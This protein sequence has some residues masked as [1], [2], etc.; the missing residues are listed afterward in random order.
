MTS[1]LSEVEIGDRRVRAGLRVVLLI[2]VIAALTPPIDDNFRFLAFA[3]AGF[4][5]LT[6]PLRRAPWRYLA[7]FA[8]VFLAIWLAALMPRVAIEEGHNVFVYPNEPTALERDLPPPVFAFMR[9]QFLEQYPER[10]CRR[11]Y[12]WMN[13]SLPD[14]VFAF[15]SDSIFEP[16]RYS[17]VVDGID[18]SS[19]GELRAT[20]ANDKRYNWYHSAHDLRRETMPFFV[21]YEV[22]GSIVGGELCWRG[23]VLWEQEGPTFDAL[24]HTTMACRAITEG[25]VGHRV[26]GVSILNDAPLEM[27]L[28]LP[29][30]YGF[31]AWAALMLHVAGTLMVVILCVRLPLSRQAVTP[32]FRQQ[33]TLMALTLIAVGAFVLFRQTDFIFATFPPLEGGNDGLTYEGLGRTILMAIADGDTMEALRGGRDVFK[34]MPGLTYFRALE[35]ILFGTTNFLYAAVLLTTPFAVW[36]VARNVASSPWA[37]WSAVAFLFLP[38]LGP[39]GLWYYTFL[40]RGVEAGF[41]EALAATFFF[42]GLALVLRHLPSPK[43]RYMAPGF[44]AGLC[45]AAAILCRPNYGPGAVVLIMFATW[46]LWRQR[47][48]GEAIVAAAGFSP[49]FLMLLHNFYFGGVFVPATSSAGDDATV[50]LTPALYVTAAIDTMRFNFQSEALNT[51]LFQWERWFRGWFLLPLMLWLFYELV[52][53]RLTWDARTIAYVALAQHAVLLF[54]VADTRFTYLAWSLT[55]L[56]LLGTIEATGR[57]LGTHWRMSKGVA[58]RSG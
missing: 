56:A 33:A 4:L 47:R 18:F 32:L 40:R 57:R 52:R 13:S 35:K 16:A 22:P 23:H 48:L 7:A 1:A 53:G 36:A 30:P 46:Y 29:A 10:T 17:R 42:A 15:S 38:I 34:N 51:L 2:G 28:Q 58:P 20:F 49:I 44:V 27:S 11:R 50:T 43:G 5:I 3:A 19:I 8:A 6:L 14:T 9:D 31:G 24:N 45:L 26:F 37:W 25:D 41:A 21:M 39:V 54:W 55:V 12:C